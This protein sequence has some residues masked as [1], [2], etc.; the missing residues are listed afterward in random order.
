MT[1]DAT[2]APSTTPT[3]SVGSRFVT[4]IAQR[5][6][7]S[8]RALLA[9]NVDF[10]G[11]TPKKFWEGSN[12]D[13]VLETVFDNWFE[14]QDHIDEVVQ[15]DQGEDVGDVKRIGYRFRITT[16]DGPHLVEQQAYYYEYD[17]QI[18]YL[19]VVCSGYRPTE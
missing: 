11:L 17:D 2:P 10:K 15:S 19:R 9:H 8:L 3:G 4:A 13:E 12:P 5:D 7:E 18:L 1:T 6:K 14:E 16:P